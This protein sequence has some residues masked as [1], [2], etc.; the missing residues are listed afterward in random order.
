METPDGKDRL[1]GK[2]GL[3]LMGRDMLRKYLVQFSVNGWGSVTSLLFDLRPNY[4]EGNKDNGN[5]SFKRPQAHTTVSSAPDTA[6]GPHQ[7]TALPEIPGYSQTSLGQSLVASLLF[8]PGSLSTQGFVC[9]LQ[10]SVSQSCVDS[11]IITLASKV[12][13]PGGSQCLQT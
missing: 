9:A 8:P 7:H 1:W 10:G 2:L 4:G 11:V 6:A 3:V 13:F 12:K 5:L